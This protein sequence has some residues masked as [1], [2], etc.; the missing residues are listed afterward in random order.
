MKNICEQNDL[1]LL[2]KSEKD[3]AHEC[4]IHEGNSQYPTPMVL[5]P[6]GVPPGSRDLSG[7]KEDLG[8]VGCPIPFPGDLGTNFACTV[9]I[10]VCILH[11]YPEGGQPTSSPAEELSSRSPERGSNSTLKSTRSS[12]DGPLNSV[13]SFPPDRGTTDKETQDTEQRLTRPVL[14][15]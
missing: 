5:I 14:G 13:K 15:P 1:L 9:L 10:A 6:R 7:D 2:M 4:E 8:F 11:M 3:K 12:T